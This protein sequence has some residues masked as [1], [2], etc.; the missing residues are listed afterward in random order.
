MTGNYT[1]HTLHTTFSVLQSSLYCTAMNCSL[2]FTALSTC[3][4]CKP[5]YSV[6]CNVWYFVLYG[7][8]LCTLYCTALY[9]VLYCTLYCTVRCT[10][11]YDVL[12]CTMYC[13]V[14]C[15]AVLYMDKVVRGL[16]CAVLYMVVPP[17][18]EH[19]KK[20]ILWTQYINKCRIDV[21]QTREKTKIALQTQLL[22][23]NQLIKWL[24]E[25]SF[26][27]AAFTA[28]ASMYGKK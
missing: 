25:S 7:T 10:V 23:I 20:W 27:S 1:C 6:H 16:T 19:Q 28:P 22:Y 21:Y 2:Q 26:S 4:Y 14:H 3:L 5:W 9:N 24:N 11:L 15:V 17:F 18:S 8:L 13:S 12:H